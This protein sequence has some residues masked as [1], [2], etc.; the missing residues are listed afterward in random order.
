MHYWNRFGNNFFQSTLLQS[1]F[2]VKFTIPNNPAP[3]AVCNKIFC[4]YG[5]I[6][7]LKNFCGLKQPRFVGTN[8]APNQFPAIVVTKL[9]PKLATVC[10]PFTC[11]CLTSVS[12][13]STPVWTVAPI[14]AAKANEAPP[15]NRK[16]L[17]FQLPCL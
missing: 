10:Q 7:T 17:S 13:V 4:P 5:L 9:I 6:N 15:V 2:L 3:I 14:A 11:S 12:S 16:C 8:F 1:N